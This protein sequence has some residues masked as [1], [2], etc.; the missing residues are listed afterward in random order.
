MC[1]R[2]LVWCLS[3]RWYSCPLGRKINPPLI[4]GDIYFSLQYD[5]QTLTDTGY[6]LSGSYFLATIFTF[7]FTFFLI[8]Y[9]GISIFLS[10]IIRAA[11]VAR[12]KEA[13]LLPAQSC[14]HCGIAQFAYC[15]DIFVSIF[16]IGKQNPENFRRSLI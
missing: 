11:A 1:G 14:I 3:T 9:D 12:V 15:A 4:V 7:S 8:I 2:R 6:I 13:K 10:G 5:Y 16:Y